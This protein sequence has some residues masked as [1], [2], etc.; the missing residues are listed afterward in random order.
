MS[1]S[2]V[3]VYSDAGVWA[4]HM[5]YSLSQEP[6]RI[7]VTVLEE[8]KTANSSWPWNLHDVKAVADGKRRAD[9]AVA[10]IEWQIHFV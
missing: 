1:P 10:F 4:E 5:R 7:L 8:E 9:E 3:A 6:A 2:N